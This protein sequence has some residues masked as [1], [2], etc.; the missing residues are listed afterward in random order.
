MLKIYNGEKIIKINDEIT[1]YILI[2]VMSEFF[3]KTSFFM[4]KSI[5][6]ADKFKDKTNKN[7]PSNIVK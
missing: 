2:I 7:I 3:I 6:F 5:F 1:K 4:G